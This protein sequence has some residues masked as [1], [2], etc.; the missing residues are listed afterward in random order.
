MKADW[1]ALYSS[2]LVLSAII[3]KMAV[4]SAIGLKQD[5]IA[6]LEEERRL[7]QARLAYTVERRKSAESTRQFMQRRKSSHLEKLA[8]VRAELLALEQ[9]EVAREKEVETKEN[10]NAATIDSLETADKA[11]VDQQQ[12]ADTVMEDPQANATDEQE[13]GVVEEK[14]GAEEDSTLEEQEL[15]ESDLTTHETTEM[16]KKEKK[17]SRSMGRINVQ[18]N[19]WQKTPSVKLKVRM[20]VWPRS[21]LADGFDSSTI[22][23]SISFGCKL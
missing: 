9:A 1:L 21:I 7:I 5:K 2:V 17:T 13:N 23:N 15:E 16:L 22:L 4:H 18:E 10:H 12:T 8:Q 20:T 11:V 6:L 14:I 3:F 19:L